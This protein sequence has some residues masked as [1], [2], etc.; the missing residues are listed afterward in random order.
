MELA[1]KVFLGL[2][3]LIVMSFIA[4]FIDAWW[5]QRKQEK[6]KEVKR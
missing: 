1:H 3:L 2:L 4:G 5:E 6:N